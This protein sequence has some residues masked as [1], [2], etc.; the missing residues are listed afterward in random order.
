MAGGALTLAV[1]I[2]IA[3]LQCL[4]RQRAGMREILGIAVHVL[5]TCAML[6][7]V[8]RIGDDGFKA[9][10][11]LQFIDAAGSLLSWPT[12]PPLGLI[13]YAPAAILFLSMFKSSWR[14]S[15]GR[16]FIIAGAGWVAAQICATA[17]GRA[18]GYPLSSRYLDALQIGMMVNLASAFVLL[19]TKWA[20]H[21][22][23]RLDRLIFAAF[24]LFLMV[25]LGLGAAN[26]KGQIDFRRKSATIEASNI[27]SYLLTGDFSYLAH[28]S[29][30]DIAYPSD[31]RLR[32][33]LDDTTI[34]RI[35]PPMLLSKQPPTSAAEKVKTFIFGTRYWLILCGILAWFLPFAVPRSRVS[36]ADSKLAADR[37]G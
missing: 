24:V 8:P 37:Q 12:K 17:L 16:W 13:A 25:S 15:D 4:R 36:V 21:R 34:R 9:H 26:L 27:R 23:T 20:E 5:L 3:F 29:Q 31:V 6:I 11:V 2:C 7:A 33:L 19:S 35:L 18:N 32:G 30:D 10:S 28:K 22:L 1:A 14:L